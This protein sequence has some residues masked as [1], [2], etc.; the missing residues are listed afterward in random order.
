MYHVSGSYFDCSL[1]QLF[2][3]QG[4]NGFAVQ[5]VLS[6]AEVQ[7]P[8]VLKSSL[9]SAFNTSASL[10]VTGSDACG[11]QMFLCSI[12]LWFK[13][14]RFKGSMPAAFK[15]PIVLLF[16]CSKFYGSRVRVQ[17]ALGGVQ[18]PSALKVQFPFASKGQSFFASS[19]LSV[20]PL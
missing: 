11:V 9:P 14:L 16:I 2:K 10:S 20:Y 13:V 8:S 19:K 1:V 18:I 4:S 5:R 15:C 17:R 7:M 12:V 3:V 6:G